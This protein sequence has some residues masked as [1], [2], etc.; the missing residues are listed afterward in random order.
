MWVA[1]FKFNQQLFISIR[2]HLLLSNPIGQK[3]N[4]FYYR[5]TLYAAQSFKSFNQKTLR[6]AI[7]TNS[8]SDSTTRRLTNTL[9]KYDNLV[10]P[11]YSEP[12]LAIDFTNSMLTLTA[13]PADAIHVEQHRFWSNLKQSLDQLASASDRYAPF[14][15]ITYYGLLF[16][17]P[18]F[19]YTFFDGAVRRLAGI[20]CKG[21]R[22]VWV[23][24]AICF[25][26]GMLLFVPMLA[27]SPVK[28][29]RKD[30]PAALAAK[31]LSVRVAA[32]RFIERNK[33]NIA[34]YPQY[35]TLLTSPQV[36]ERYYLARALAFNSRPDTVYQ[37][38][39]LSR[40]PHPN[41]VCQAYYAL[42]VRKERRAVGQIQRQLMQTDH[43]Y[44]QWYGYRA[45]RRMGWRQIQS[46]STD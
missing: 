17:F 33:I 12:D 4:D 25:S 27:R 3:I 43:W 2:D 39:Q 8:P 20:F 5:N 6:T 29:T 15:Q 18:I 11:G 34:T 31:E 26:M 30:L 24:A 9:A 19:L 7:I 32:L 37:L 21:R 42:G 13:P 16:G 1:H 23:R 10:T 14:R 44:T 45:L 38:L 41:V 46:K 40:D 35:P 28:M 36:V 22:L